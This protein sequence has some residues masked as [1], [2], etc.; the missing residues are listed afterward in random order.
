[1]TAAPQ[2]TDSDRT[3]GSPVRVDNGNIYGIFMMQITMFCFVTNDTLSKLAGSNLPT[4]QVIFIRGLIAVAALGLILAL[5]GDWRRYRTAKNP[6]VLLRAFAE[7]IS[8]IL[9]MIG[10]QQLPLPNVSAI[11]L[12]IPLITTAAAAI[13]MG[14]Q[15]GIRRWTSIFIGM[16]G[17]LAII[18][19]GL[20]GFNVY[21]LFVL[22]AVVAAS[23]RD[24][25]A[26][27]IPTGSSLWVVTATT[28]TFSC[29][30]GGLLGV[31]ESWIAIDTSQTIFLAGAAIFL[32]LGQFV[33]VIAMTHG[34]VSVV[35]S[36][37][38]ISMPISLFYG[39]MLWG[40][41]PDSLTWLGIFLILS[42]GIYTMYRERQ[43]QK[44]KKRDQEILASHE[45]V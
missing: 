10:L 13:F 7:A 36:F 8:S 23:I 4:G 42:S 17:V 12:T 34:E 45:P 20:E 21:S 29:L 14:E 19:P 16:L 18:R 3:S 28:M 37:R 40:D 2:G 39:F 41:I 38:Y 24:L 25:I 27:K 1:M 43:I 5:T 35:S 31:S 26:R 11:L 9:F 15:V 30:A 33:V 32:T 22:G 44:V 6:I